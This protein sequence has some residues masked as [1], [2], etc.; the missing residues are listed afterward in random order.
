MP[1][2]ETAGVALQ[3]RYLLV[4]QVCTREQKKAADRMYSI[5]KS[6]CQAEQ[7]KSILPL[8]STMLCILC[9]F[10]LSAARC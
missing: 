2:A 10:L 3:D 6:Y 5:C 1:M 7:K 8:V 9:F 4:P